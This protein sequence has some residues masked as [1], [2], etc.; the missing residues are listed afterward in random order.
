M[1][2]TETQG[3]KKLHAE[4]TKEFFVKMITRDIA[5][6]DCIFDLLD[7]AIDGAHRHSSQPDEEEPLAGSWAKIVFDDKKFQIEDN[8]GGIRL[9][10]AIDYAF[11]FG[12]RPGS[13]ADV[14]GGIGLY[15]IGMKRAI[16][17]IGQFADIFSEA[18]DATFGVTVDVPAWAKKDDWDFDYEDRVSRGVK[19]TRIEISNL[20]PGIDIAFTDP[21]FRNELI[22]QIARDYAFFI[23]K[24]FRISVCGD[25]VPSFQYKMRENNDLKAN[26]TDLRF[27]G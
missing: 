23:N 19:G 24:G 5:L 21:V 12:R 17:K 16:F 1:A 15:G 4:P 8:C 9:D 7:N 22:K 18:D 25:N 6:Q 20:I 2:E 10:D 14:A 27:Y 13:A 26:G 11:H 3:V